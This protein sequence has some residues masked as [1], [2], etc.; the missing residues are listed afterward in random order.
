MFSLGV[1]PYPGMESGP[2]LFEFLLR[3]ERMK[4]PNFAPGYVYDIMLGCWKTLPDNRLTFRRIVELLIRE[5]RASADYSGSISPGFA[6]GMSP[7][8]RNTSFANRAYGFP[9]VV[10]ASGSPETQISPNIDNTALQFDDD[11]YLVSCKQELDRTKSEI[12][13]ESL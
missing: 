13:R 10:P 3:G 12:L 8:E 7:L 4:C 6:T 2:R 9:D 11:G 1:T 5:I